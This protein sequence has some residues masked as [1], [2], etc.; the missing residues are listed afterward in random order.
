M[1][2]QFGYDT[3]RDPPAPVLPIRIGKPGTE[4]T[5]A[6]IALVDSG[7]DSTVIPSD[8]AKRLGLPVVEQIKVTGVGGVTQRAS[9]HA[10]EVD[11]TGFR[12]LIRVIGLGQEA[13]LGRDLLNQ[14]VVT[15]RGPE[16]VMDVEVRGK[17]DEGR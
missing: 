11:T 10:A 17:K 5:L 13:L 8:V 3:R 16:Q 7:A 4:P 12:G 14:W 9:M 1:S 6:L 2:Q 15:L